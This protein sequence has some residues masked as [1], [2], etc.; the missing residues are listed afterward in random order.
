MGVIRTSIEPAHLSRGTSARHVITRLPD[1]APASDRPPGPGDIWRRLA[2]LAEACRRGQGPSPTAAGL[3]A[4]IGFRPGRRVTAWIAT[5][6]GGDGA[7]GLVTLVESRPGAGGPPR[8]SIGWL[9]VDPAERRLGLGSALV[10]A[11]VAE[12]V[13]RGADRV[14]AETRSDWAGATAFWR[15]LSAHAGG[16][17]PDVAAGGGEAG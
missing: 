5:R 7:A 9:L 12:A 16:G 14:T 11:A 15:R 4:E 13:A 10:A 1:D 2:G 3:R 17:G 8:Y 6:P